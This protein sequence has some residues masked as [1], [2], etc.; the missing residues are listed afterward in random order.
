M[1][2]MK[3]PKNWGSLLPRGSRA[4]GAVWYR[5]KLLDIFAVLYA[6]MKQLSP[7]LLINAFLPTA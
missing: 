7:W 5:A 1:Y 4:C 2:T 6:S 3:P